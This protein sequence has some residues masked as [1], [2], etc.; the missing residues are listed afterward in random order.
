MEIIQ[1]VREQEKLIFDDVSNINNILFIRNVIK[2]NIDDDTIV[3][4]TLHSL[5]RIF[6]HLLDTAVYS[7]CKLN[8]NTSVFT[9]LNKQYKLFKNSLYELIFQNRKHIVAP[10]LRTLIEFVKRDYLVYSSDNVFF[11]Y[12]TFST[13]LQKLLACPN[14]DI[15]IVLMMRQEIFHLAD[16]SYYAMRAVYEVLLTQKNAL[17]TNSHDVVV[18]QNAL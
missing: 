2:K 7:S 14:L 6:I 8:K 18:L 16:C 5:R 15:D 11:G 12:E 13:I 10:S 4:A 3:L 1:A 17:A 9:W